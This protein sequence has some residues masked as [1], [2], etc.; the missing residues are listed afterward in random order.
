MHIHKW[1][2]PQLTNATISGRNADS[3]GAPIA[4]IY[5]R[6]LFCLTNTSHV[7]KY[8]QLWAEILRIFAKSDSMEHIIVFRVWF[9][10]VTLNATGNQAG[11]YSHS[12]QNLVSVDRQLS[13]FD[14]PPL[15]SVGN[16]MAAPHSAHSRYSRNI[17]TR[18][19]LVKWLKLHFHRGIYI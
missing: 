17:S 7:Q 4:M 2:L 11:V 5:W 16:S 8:L 1:L 3:R 13:L 18:S 10:K 9:K 15:V 19:T 14:F 6:N 12:W